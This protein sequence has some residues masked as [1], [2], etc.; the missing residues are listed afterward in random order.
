M[1]LL[2]KVFIAQG[3]SALSQGDTDS[4]AQSAYDA[5]MV[6]EPKWKMQ[7]NEDLRLRKAQILL[8]QGRIA[9]KNGNRPEAEMKLQSAVS[10]LEEN[11][12]GELPFTRLDDLV[13]ALELAG[14]PD[15]AVEYKKRLKASGFVPLQPYP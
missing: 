4:A 6:I 14:K 5:F 13:R 3:Q 7:A 11:A 12:G 1:Y 15:R 10:L 8:L 9:L 2:A